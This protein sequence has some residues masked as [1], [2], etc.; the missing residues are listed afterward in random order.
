MIA[1]AVNVGTGTS[2]GTGPTYTY[3]Y[4]SMGRLNGM[5]DQSSNT[6]VNGIAYGPA[7]EL[8]T[9]SYLEYNETRQ[10]NSRLQMTRLTTTTTGGGGSIDSSTAL[11]PTRT[12]ARS[13]RKRTG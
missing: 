3:G 9:M 8:L 5:T 7:G 10:Y 6:L 11:R 13:R 4:H 2:S 12:T 1:K